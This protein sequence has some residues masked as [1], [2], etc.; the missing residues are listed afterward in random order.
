MQKLSPRRLWLH[1]KKEGVVIG[2][3]RDI[4]KI[5]GQYDSHHIYQDAAVNN[6]KKYNYYDAVAIS[7]KARNSNKTTKGT[8]HYLANRAQD[9]S[10]K[11]GVLGAET[12]VA[13]NSLKAAGLSS[14]AAKC[15][16]LKARN[17]FTSLGANAGTTTKQLSRRKGK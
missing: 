10:S 3:H 14:K 11:A 1:I 6:I 12:V 16:T 7:L 13:Y 2:K 5:G 8:P 4:K 17:Y 15:A 9:N